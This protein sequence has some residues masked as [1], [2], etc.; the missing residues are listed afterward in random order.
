M[1]IGAAGKFRSRAIAALILLSA[2]WALDG[3][4]PDLF[5]ALRYSPVPAL[6]R[7]AITYAVFAVGAAMYAIA[8]G[9]RWPNFARAASWAGTGVLIFP[10][11]LLLTFAARGSV[12]QYERVAIFALV[13]VFAIVLEP[14]LGNQSFRGNGALLAA[15]ISVAGALTIFPLAVPGR[16]EAMVAV[17]AVALAAL[18]AAVGN[19]LAV[20][21]AASQTGYSTATFATWS[22]GAAALAFAIA[23]ISI[24]RAEW[25]IPSNMIQIVWSLA[26]EL[27]PLLPLFWLFSRMSATRMTAR[28]LLAPL[29]TVLA[30]IAL[31][32]PT[33]NARMIIGVV[34]LAAGTAW[35]VFASD[36]ES[37]GDSIRILS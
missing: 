5:P 9:V 29:L 32:Q 31:E 16:P 27:A 6:E 36:R 15:L 4:A 7:L 30:G 25:H 17:L 2:L 10:V 28:F 18:S 1:S 37:A 34:L 26:I 33:I 22:S 14:H 11:P 19:C 21:F 8:R 13:P 23:G 12:S 3:L 20:R 35:L 24:P